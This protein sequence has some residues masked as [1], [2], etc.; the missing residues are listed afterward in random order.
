VF[1]PRKQD[2]VATLK[3][4]IQIAEQFPKNSIIGSHKANEMY[5][6]ENKVVENV[7][8]DED[9]K[10]KAEKVTDE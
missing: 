4:S 2:L 5:F 7:E 9:E 8:L 10:E 1:N 6:N 3:Q